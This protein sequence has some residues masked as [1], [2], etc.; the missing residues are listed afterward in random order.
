MTAWLTW[1]FDANVTG[2]CPMLG[3]VLTICQCRTIVVMEIKSNHLND[4]N[5]NK[6]HGN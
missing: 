2:V 4:N 3:P 6:L 5:H 1:I